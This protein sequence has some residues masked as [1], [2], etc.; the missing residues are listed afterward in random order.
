MI[1]DIHD[2]QSAGDIDSVDVEAGRDRERG[3]GR[4]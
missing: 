4:G 2:L 1:E 3:R